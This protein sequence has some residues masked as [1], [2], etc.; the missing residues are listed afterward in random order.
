MSEHNSKLNQFIQTRKLIYNL[1][2]HII[3]IIIINS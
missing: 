1:Q 3:I 2:K